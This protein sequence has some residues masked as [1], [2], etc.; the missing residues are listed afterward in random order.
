MTEHEGAGA[1]P[2]A[3]GVL[4]CDCPAAGSAFQAVGVGTTEVD[5]PDCVVEQAVERAFMLVLF[6]PAVPRADIAEAVAL[7]RLAGCAV[8]IVVCSA[9]ESE[10]DAS[11]PVT[12][13]VLG[14]P[15]MATA[16]SLLRRYPR[17]PSPGPGL[18][19]KGFEEEFIA[20]LK[21]HAAAFFRLLGASD[22]AGLRRE[23][24]QARGATA[25]FRYKRLTALTVEMDRILRVLSVGR[26]G[27]AAREDLEAV[28]ARFDRAVK[29]LT[30]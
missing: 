25:V 13:L 16:A 28:T 18:S 15:D 23:V 20:A 10:A 3:T 7:M 26:G 17:E 1:C 22:W 5:S 24:H 19:T 30:H 11:L 12:E 2:N 14:V 8:P 9:A 21:G 6:G 27:E 4:V 29:K